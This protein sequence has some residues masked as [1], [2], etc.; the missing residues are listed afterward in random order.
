MRTYLIYVKAQRNGHHSAINQ[1]NILQRVHTENG[2]EPPS[3]LR[4]FVTCCHNWRMQATF[5]SVMWLNKVLL[6]FV[7]VFHGYL[8]L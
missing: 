6:R 8:R 2:S 1:R 4:R 7:S 3:L 5:V